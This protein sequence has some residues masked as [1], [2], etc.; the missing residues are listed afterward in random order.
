[1]NPPK[2][3]ISSPT[4]IPAQTNSKGV[5]SLSTQ[6]MHHK[7]SRTRLVSIKQKL[8]EAYSSSGVSE[9]L[10]AYEILID[11]VKTHCTL[12]RLKRETSDRQLV[13][14][15]IKPKAYVNKSKAIS[16]RWDRLDWRLLSLERLRYKFEQEFLPGSL[17]E[18]VG[19]GYALLKKFLYDP[20]GPCRREKQDI[21]RGDLIEQYDLKSPGG[22]MWDRLGIV[23]YA[24]GHEGRP[25]CAIQ[26]A[27][28]SY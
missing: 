2:K 23:C 24:Y 7:D 20:R 26:P 1:M 16:T 22:L 21:F 18:E 6:Y 25:H 3:Q 15:M 27:A 11:D 5:I 17:M 28:G 14:E 9:V 10:A 8:K 12:L 19:V 13:K 4:K